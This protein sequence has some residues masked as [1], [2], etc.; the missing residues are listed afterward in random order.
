MKKQRCSLSFHRAKVDELDLFAIG[1]RDGIYTNPTIFTA[2][3]YTEVE[4]QAFI[5][6][7]ANTRGAY[8]QGGSAQK[9]PFEAAKT[10]LMTALDT[11]ATTV[12]NLADGDANI[13]TI[14]GYVA[15]KGTSS[16][17]PE[18]AQLKD[19]KLSRGSSGQLLAECENQKGVDSYVCIMSIGVPMPDGVG[20]DAAGQLHI[21]E[22]TKPPA[23]DEE[24]PLGVPA[25]Q[26]A[27]VDFKKSRK[28]KFIGLAPGTTYYFVFF[29]VNARGVG[30][31]SKEVNIVCW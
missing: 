5:D 16:S 20:I 10:A 18:P 25:T 3:P 19:V 8:K 23:G 21:G 2:P 9:G 22:G 7:Y 28:K 17:A 14:A 31:F 1:V 13:I 6:D 27:I 29:G 30:P 11:T 15:T 24:T 4:F 12:D 26:P